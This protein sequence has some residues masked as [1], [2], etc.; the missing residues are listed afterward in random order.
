ME[1]IGRVV[2]LNGEFVP[3]AEAKISIYDSA[4]MFCDMVF[5]MTRSFN[6]KQFKLREH[7][8]RLYVGLAI[9]RIPMSMSKDEL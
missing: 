9:L 1:K 2:Y 3:E 8:D 4:F 7:I 6:G 5:E